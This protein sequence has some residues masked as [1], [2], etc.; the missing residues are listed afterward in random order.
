MFLLKEFQ[1]TLSNMHFHI[2]GTILAHT[3]FN[4]GLSICLITSVYY[5]KFSLQIHSGGKRC[6]IDTD[7]NRPDIDMCIDSDTA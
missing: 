6:K 2:L 1:L 3:V 5:P 4:K 7:F